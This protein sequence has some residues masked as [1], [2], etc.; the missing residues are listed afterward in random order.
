MKNVLK[1]FN[2]FIEASRVLAREPGV[3]EDVEILLFGKTKKD[4]GPSFPLRTRNIAFVQ[5]IR[6]I[7]ELYSVAHLFAIPSLQD[8]LPNTILE[9]MLCGTP[10]VGFSSGGI[11]EMIAHK[12][13]GY[14]AEYKSSD[15]L[16]AGMSWVLS[17]ES[18]D[19]L[20]A[21]T[22]SL[23]LERFSMD[24][25]VEKHRNLYRKILNKDK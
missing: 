22:R 6:T 10:V 4:E 7:V 23:A 16:A 3:E 11:P 18:Y 20:S 14:L 15:D 17:S 21:K 24:H 8:N 2:Y 12:E 13:S 9:S 5:S 19:Q 1:G 25:S